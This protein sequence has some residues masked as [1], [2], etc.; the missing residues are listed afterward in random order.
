MRME[1]RDRLVAAAML[2][3]KHKYAKEGV[4]DYEIEP[5]RRK[6]YDDFAVNNL[7]YRHQE[8]LMRYWKKAIIANIAPQKYLNGLSDYNFKFPYMIGDPERTFL[9]AVQATLEDEPRAEGFP[10]AFRQVPEER[11]KLRDITRYKPSLPETISTDIPSFEDRKQARL[12]YDEEMAPFQTMLQRRTSELTLSTAPPVE[13]MTPMVIASKKIEQAAE[14]D[15]QKKKKAE[16][17]VLKF[18]EDILKAQLF[19]GDIYNGLTDEEK[20][21]FRATVDT[22]PP[23]ESIEWLVNKLEGHQNLTFEIFVNNLC[24]IHVNTFYTDGKRKKKFVLN[25]VH[26]KHL[27]PRKLRRYLEWKV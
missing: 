14:A 17:D 26:E 12:E 13:T 3:R 11:Q 24:F 27:I 20:E 18:A 21:V 22:A 6:S 10:C 19:E 4:I 25:Y 23:Y 5:P 15:Y 16:S 8:E 9:K 1:R 7:K 2:T